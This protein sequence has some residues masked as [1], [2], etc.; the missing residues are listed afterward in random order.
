MTDIKTDN[1][2]TRWCNE[3]PEFGGLLMYPNQVQAFLGVVRDEMSTIEAAAAVE[4]IRHDLTHLFADQRRVA[5]TVDFI[6]RL[7]ERDNEVLIRNAEQ[8]PDSGLEDAPKLIE[9]LVEAAVVRGHQSAL[10]AVLEYLT[11]P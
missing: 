5:S 9:N 10:E 6:E 11:R 4:Q 3:H 1:A 8:R 7:T 2:V